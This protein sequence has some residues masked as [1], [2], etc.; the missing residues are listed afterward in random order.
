MQ[1]LLLILRLIWSPKSLAQVAIRTS[2]VLAIV[3]GAVVSAFAVTAILMPGFISVGEPYLKFWLFLLECAKRVFLGAP[4]IVLISTPLIILF[5]LIFNEFYSK[6]LAAGCRAIALAPTCF[7]LPVLIW[8][9]AMMLVWAQ[10]S[11]VVMPNTVPQWVFSPVFRFLASPWWLLIML[12]GGIVLCTQAVLEVKRTF[13]RP[14]S[15]NCAECGYFLKGLPEPRC[16][17]C[18]KEF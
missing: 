6:R 8:S 5:V 14:D 17:E 13:P 7:I 12:L 1:N 3:F 11:D 16:P 4:F 9:L 18:G 15:P 2:N 10:H